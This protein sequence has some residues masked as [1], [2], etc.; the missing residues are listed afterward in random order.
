MD[1]HVSST[2]AV[3]YWLAGIET[4]EDA[5]LPIVDVDA[6]Q[7][8]SCASP[9]SARLTHYAYRYALDAPFQQMEV[10]DQNVDSLDDLN[11][12]VKRRVESSSVV[13]YPKPA[14]SLRSH[15]RKRRKGMEDTKS[16]T[17]HHR[18][19]RV[20][21]ISSN[22][23]SE[24]SSSR[25]TSILSVQDYEPRFTSTSSKRAQSIPKLSARSKTTLERERRKKIDARNTRG[26]RN[27]VP[28]SCTDSLL[29]I[30]PLKD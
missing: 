25:S 11:T 8:K 2:E 5:P 3:R 17:R 13:S 20:I 9:P 27:P 15:P 28:P 14:S 22:S 16:S 12:G 18:A 24:D 29:V 26:K 30:S 6:K 23:S 10:R 4:C 1:E 21:T 19:R 7:P